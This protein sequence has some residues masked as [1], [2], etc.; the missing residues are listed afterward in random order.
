VIDHGSTRDLITSRSRF[1]R[2]PHARTRVG[3]DRIGSGTER[4]YVNAGAVPTP[5]K[6]DRKPSLRINGAGER[7]P[8]DFDSAISGGTTR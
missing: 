7:G 1:V 3:A 5:G 2:A 6:L 4:I 8:A